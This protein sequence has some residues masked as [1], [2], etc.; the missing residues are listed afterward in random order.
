MHADTT[1]GG[2]TVGDSSGSGDLADA[3]HMCEFQAARTQ[4]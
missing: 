2:E 1:Q 4:S 3:I